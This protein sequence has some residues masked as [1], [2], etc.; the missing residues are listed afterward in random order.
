[1]VLLNFVLAESALEL[2][3][4][5]I[6]SRPAVVSDATRRE[7]KA[8]EIL[9]DRSFHHSAMERLRD[10]EKRGRPDLVHITLL[11][12]T[13]S[14]LYLDGRVMVYVHTYPDTV[15]EIEPKTR[16]PK[17][18]LR[19]RG[20]MEKCLVER[21][22]TGLLRV[23]QMSCSAL[24]KM[25]GPGGAYGLSVRGKQSS[26]PDFAKRVADEGNACVV[27]GGFPHGHFSAE[28]ARSFDELV[29]I[30]SRPLEA[31]VVAARLIYQVEE[32][33]RFND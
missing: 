21:P 13:G 20:L 30:D 33:I 32:A 14:P 26:L 10:S 18:Y 22:T 19:F 25:V 29:R 16:I 6:W 7:R 11:D 15:I 1:M 31:H 27:V 23:R 28:T 5:E 17:N 24:L 9:L 3:P 2:V 4:R 12:V 8:G